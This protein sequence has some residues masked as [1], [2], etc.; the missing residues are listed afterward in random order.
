MTGTRVLLTGAATMVGAEVLKELLQ[1]HELTSIQLFLWSDKDARARTL[2]RLQAYLGALPPGV[3]TAAGDLRLPRFGMSLTTWDEFAQ[4]FDVAIHC[5]Q[6]EVQDQD[7]ALARQANVLPVENW[8]HVLDRNPALR[9]HH[10]ST[11]FIGGTRRGLLTEFDLA[12][13]QGFHN[14]FERSK[15]EAEVRLRESRVSDR[16]TIHRPSHLLGRAPTGQAFELGGAYPLLATLAAASILP[17]DA[18]ARVDLVPADYVAEAMVALVCAGATGT[19][20]LACGWDT[21]LPVKRAAQ[22]AA[23]AR[24]RSGSAWLLPRGV[25]WPLGILGAAT[26]NGLSSRGLAFATARDLLHQGPVFDTYLADLALEPLGIT[27]PWPEHWLE[28]AVHG[29]EARHWEAPGDSEFARPAGQA[30]LPAAAAEASIRKDPVFREKR[31]HQVGDVNVA[32]RDIGSGEPVV[33]LHGYAGAHAWDGVVERIAV[34]RRALVIETLGLGETEGSASA[35]FSLAA[36]AARV[37]GLLSALDISSAHVVG[38]DT[39]GVIAQ[40][41]AVRWPHCVKSLVLSDCV[42]SQSS[43]P[44]S[45]LNMVYDKRLLTDERLALHEQMLAGTRERRLRLKRFLRALDQ[46]DVSTLNQQLGQL[47]VPTM[48]IWGGENAYWSPSWASTL[49]DS[50]P[51][52]RRLELI[53]F[54]GISCHEERPD[55]FARKLS[56]FFDERYQSSGTS[57]LT[58]RV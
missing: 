19:F 2:G 33:F 35:D 37:R 29:G 32:Y 8:I 16:V 47:D 50:I 22:L 36:Q 55:V 10:L 21:S 28:A 53:P 38:N 57:A 34:Q 24:G 30:T 40:F 17:G 42:A 15:Y 11:G 49:Y 7:L 25:A 14:A 27:R 54:A 1:R 23:K 9:L 5:A 31:F 46:T 39:G 4:S 12:C 20:H 13:G 52:A 51:G 6:R 58:S 56:E 43:E 44:P 18:R 48:I 41:F 45:L 26:P 3:T